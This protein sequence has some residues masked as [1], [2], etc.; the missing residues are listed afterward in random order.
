MSRKLRLSLLTVALAAIAIATAGVVSAAPAKVVGTVGPGETISL[1][2]GGKKVTKL[3]AGVAYRLVVSD[4]SDEHDFRITGPGVNKVITSVGFV[5]RKAVV[6]KLK[7]GAYSYFC[8][9]H[10]DD[11]HGSFRVAR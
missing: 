1:R 3:K 9:P 4:R 11:M 5:G 8:M 7:A 6:L 10:S 2:L